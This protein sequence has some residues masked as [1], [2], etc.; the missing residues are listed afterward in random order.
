MAG[1]YVHV[2]FC[3]K[4]CHYC[5]FHFSTN[6]SRKRDLVQAIA[7]EI[8]LRANAFSDSSLST[9]YFGGGTPSLLSVEELELVLTAA[10]THFKVDDHVEITLEANPEDISVETLKAWKNIGIN[11]LSIGTQSFNNSILKWMNRAHSGNEAAHSVNL[12][13]DMGLTNVTIDLIYGVNLRSEGEW[14]Q[15][16]NTALG[17]GAPHLSAYCLTIE[18]NTVFGRRSNK[19]EDLEQSD[20]KNSTEFLTLVD[21][22]ASYGLNQYEVSNFSKVGMESRHNSNY[23]NRSE[24]IGVGPSAHSFLGLKRRW[25][26]ANNSS[27]IKKVNSNNAYFEEEHLTKEDLIN[28]IIMTSLRRAEGLSLALLKGSYNYN[29]RELFHSELKSLIDRGLAL[30]K[31]DFLILT[32]NGLLLADRIASEFFIVNDRS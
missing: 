31:D 7:L 11:R 12:A 3:R 4:A 10:Y 20:D 32:L 19:G 28:E 6:L 15:E 30:I 2:P 17:L 14:E 1:L 23:W 22:A 26:V 18:E 5:D 25:N 13:L 29:I 8:K 27:Y 9:I 21:H 16:L 24:Y